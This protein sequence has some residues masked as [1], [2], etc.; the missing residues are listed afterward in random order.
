[1]TP[2]RAFS[3]RRSANGKS[4]AHGRRLH[5]SFRTTGKVPTVPEKDFTTITLET[6]LAYD[7]R[8]LTIMSQF[9]PNDQP[10]FFLRSI[11]STLPSQQPPAERLSAGRGLMPPS[12]EQLAPEAAKQSTSPKPPVLVAIYEYHPQR[13]DELFVSIGDLFHLLDASTPD[14]QFVESTTSSR[15]GWV[16]AGCL[17]EASRNELKE[18]VEGIAVFDYAPVGVNERRLKL[19]EVLKVEQKFEQWVHVSDKGGV[20]G[21]VPTCYVSFGTREQDISAMT[22]MGITPD[23]NRIDHVVT[24]CRVILCMYANDSI[25]DRDRKIE[26]RSCGRL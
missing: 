19:G 11:R 15:S 7:D 17:V 3:K 8:P 23:V 16:P 14:W 25:G 5:S 2:A 9:K 18:P 24:V 21:W 20:R 22:P 1:M 26:R 10:V 6:C 13:E 4:Q 12:T